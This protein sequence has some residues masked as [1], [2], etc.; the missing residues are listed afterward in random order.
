MTDYTTVEIN[1]KA[2]IK[3]LEELLERL[4]SWLDDNPGIVRDSQAHRDIKTHLGKLKYGER[5]VYQEDF[6][7]NDKIYRRK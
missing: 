6:E 2:R 3:S 4:D 1:Q 5:V 7:K